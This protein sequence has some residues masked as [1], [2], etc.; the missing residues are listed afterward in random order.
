MKQIPPL[1]ADK[2]A[3]L[4]RRLKGAIGRQGDARRICRRPGD[5]PVPLSFAQHQIWVIDQLVP[6]NPAYNLPVGY[7]LSGPL[8]VAALEDSFSEV[9]KRHEAL[10]TSFAVAGGDPRQ[11]I[12]PAFRVAIALT[13]LTHL[14]GDE[15]EAELRAHA[16]AEAATPFD[17]SRLPLVRVRLFRLGQTEHVLIVNVH[18]IVADGLSLGLLMAELD[19]FY[20]AF[21]EGGESRPPE[22]GVQ[23][24]DFALWQRQAAASDGAHAGQIEF[25]RKQLGG[26]LPVLEM[27][28]DKRR[29]AAQ[30]FRGSNVFFTI[31]PGLTRELGALGAQ[32]ECQGCTLFMTLLAA[33]QVLL[34]RYSGAEDIVIGTPIAARAVRETEPLIGNFLNMVALRSDL[35]GDPTFSELL[36]RARDGAL[37]ALSNSELPFEILVDH[38]NFKRD[39]SRNPLFQTM[40][41]V[42]PATAPKLGGLQV[43]RFHFDLKFAQL[44]LSLH[45]YGEGEGYQGRF[46]YC[47]DLFHADTV[48]RLSA[49]FLQ[50]LNGIVTNP[51][52]AISRLPI[53]SASDRSRLL[54]EW[55]DTKADNRA[56]A[57]MHGLFEAQAARAPQR[58]AL[59]FGGQ[60]LSYG[61]LEARATR[62]AQALRS[63]GVGRGQRVGLCL[64]RGADMLAA[65][66]GVLK[67]G[68]AYVPLD[69]MF[70]QERLRF[71]AEDAQLVA[72][73]VHSGL[74]GCLRSAARASAAA[75]RRCIGPR[76]ATGS[77]AGPGCGTGRAP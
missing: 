52:Q 39:P 21:T 58:T 66:L 22:L 46:E 13:D 75:G 69:P 8:D 25:W 18:H 64:E 38:V 48:E 37:D 51:H 2:Q 65:V 61:E 72:A 14:H 49:N 36:C 34:Q 27:P 3:L 23:Y 53:L 71:M 4:E 17:L 77:A 43:R 68:A 20:R 56:A 59:R 76:F 28:A 29:P 16:S 11:V 9:V 19:T 1:S 62:M 55:N 10:R 63:R 35:A 15:R 70:P 31:S 33:F 45:L 50:L 47:T 12:H 30:S 7:R 26:T 40:L 42:L 5:A 73:G 54:D 41:Q 6:G 60:S 74:G 44:D 24:G 57:L 32:G 67:A